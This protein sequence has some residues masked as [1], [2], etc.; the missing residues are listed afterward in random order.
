MSDDPEPPKPSPPTESGAAESLGRKI[1]AEIRR[2][3]VAD[4]ARTP[5]AK[6]DEPTEDASDR[7]LARALDKAA[8]AEVEAANNYRKDLVGFTKWTVAGLVVAATVFM[9]LYI[10]SQWGEVEAS[11]MVAYF[12]SIVLEVVGILYVIA[13]YLFPSS[14]TG[15][16]NPN[17]QDRPPVEP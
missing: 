14:G 6:L 10:G 8:L 16:K 12:T 15:H 1:G 9:G 11:V 7:E 17:R 13:R 4:L 5:A 2:I 3:T